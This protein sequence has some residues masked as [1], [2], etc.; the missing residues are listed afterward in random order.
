MNR[1]FRAIVVGILGFG[2]NAS[3]ADGTNDVKIVAP[4]SAEN[5]A[6]VRFYG[7]GFTD[8]GGFL[9]VYGAANFSGAMLIRSIAF[10]A[11]EGGDDTRL[12]F[13]A[14]IPR[15]TLRMSTYTRGIESFNPRVYDLN[16]SADSST[17]FDGSV[18]WSGQNALGNAPN[19]FNM[20]IDLQAPFLFDPRKGSLLVE[21]LTSGSFALSAPADLENTDPSVGF[22]GAG[23]GVEHSIVVTEF[24]GTNVPEPRMIHLLILGAAACLLRKLRT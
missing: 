23:L 17:T 5:Q 14:V 16:A 15:V 2:M 21:F 8:A 4:N 1:F 10:R 18:H 24:G 19:P 9:S 12:S 6:G 3:A 13:D 7:S 11:D 20:R 22:S